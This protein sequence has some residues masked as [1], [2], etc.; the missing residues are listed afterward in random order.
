MSFL[1]GAVTARPTVNSFTFIQDDPAD[2]NQD[3]TQV[4]EDTNA[5]ETTFDIIDGVP[6]NVVQVQDAA[7]AAEV[8]EAPGQVQN[9]GEQMEQRPRE[10]ESGERNPETP[11]GES[12][13]H[14]SL[15]PRI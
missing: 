9:P 14:I 8:L 13:E 7:S 11:A 2:G 5:M 4:T 12:L 1:A 10:N 6:I 3:Q 15:L